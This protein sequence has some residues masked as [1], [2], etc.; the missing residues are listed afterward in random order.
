MLAELVLSYFLQSNMSSSLHTA[1]RPYIDSEVR[2]VVENRFSS[3]WSV[4]IE[5]YVM[6]S[7]GLPRIAGA[8]VEIEFDINPKAR[9][10]LYHH[11]SHNLD[12]EGIGLNIDQVKL[13][14]RF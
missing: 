3:K 13:K 9:I 10:S 11:S 14:I 1:K 4:K 8:E 2:L 7:T 12:V 6:L 5:P